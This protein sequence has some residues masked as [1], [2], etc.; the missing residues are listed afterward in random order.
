MKL[1]VRQ[2]LV[3]ITV[4]DR[5]QR[6]IASIPGYEMQNGFSPDRGCRDSDFCMKASLTKRKEHGHETWVGF[7]DLKK[8]FGTIPRKKANGEEGLLWKVLR[9]L[10]CPGHLLNL[11]KCLHDKVILDLREGEASTS[12]HAHRGVR[13]GDIIGPPLFN[14]Y[15]AAIM[16]TWNKKK[17]TE[18]VKFY[19][20]PYADRN[21]VILRGRPTG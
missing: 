8:A 7:L 15:M 16:I 19:C 21:K 11:L 20:G 1:C 18:R 9:L 13:Q 14:L 5:R 4:G 12:V 10:G 3:L 2:K 6:L 17:T